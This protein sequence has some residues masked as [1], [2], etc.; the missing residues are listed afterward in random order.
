VEKQKS[1]GLA[2]KG[3][4][5]GPADRRSRRSPFKAGVKAALTFLRR[6]PRDKKISRAKTAAVEASKKFLAD[7]FRSGKAMP[8]KVDC[9]YQERLEFGIE[10]QSA[11]SHYAWR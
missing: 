9:G 10:K 7:T 5:G 2:E 4:E 8:R 3:V 1:G 6:A 11:M